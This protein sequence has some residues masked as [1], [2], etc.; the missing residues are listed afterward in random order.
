MPIKSPFERP[1]D[2]SYVEQYPN[3]RAQVKMR[4]TQPQQSTPPPITDRHGFVQQTSPFLTERYG[5][6][7]KLFLTLVNNIVEDPDY[8]LRKD[9]KV[10][11]RMLRD[12]QIHYCLEVRKAATTSLEW[13]VRPPDAFMQDSTALKLASDAY[14]RLY[15]IKHITALF[16][17]ILDGMLPGLSVNELV[18]KI[19]SKGQY[20]VERHFPMNKDRFLFD[21]VGNL[22]LKQPV[23]VVTGV[24]V[25]PYKFIAKTF[26]ASDGS[27]DRPEDAGYVF[28]GKGLADTPLYH[29]FYF[30]MAALRYLLK[31]LEQYGIPTKI[32]YT[33][34][35][36]I[37]LTSRLTEILTALQNDSVVGIPGKKGD[38]DVDVSKQATGGTSMNLFI[39]FIEYVDRLITRCILG[40]ELM[41]EMPAV[42]S[43]AAAQV[44]Q[45]VFARIAET[46]KAQLQD[47]INSTL[48]RYD[49]EL[50]T[51]GVP[52][53]MRPIFLF[54]SS[55]MVDTGSFLQSVSTAIQL[56]LTISEAQ[57]R[58]LTGLREPQEGEAVLSAQTQMAIQQQQL[59]MQAEMTPPEE[60][61]SGIDAKATENAKDKSKT[62]SASK[63]T[64]PS[65]S[66]K[67]SA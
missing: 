14:H 6:F 15:Q 47:T 25:P 28:F 10:Y 61:E 3:I 7:D 40:Q 9:P 17:N 44:H 31:T 5:G 62:K 18:W 13:Q 63:D 45:S 57:V 46:D 67:K 32:F 39:Q 8:A 12:P 16:D 43:Y 55:P 59:Q 34:A 36:N 23:S 37:Q 20:I 29:Y 2:N 35:G 1:V 21:R 49:C 42:G 11:R 51:P 33:G 52:E 22:R 54:K 41:T 65:K 50:N 60:K 4:T 38:V 53:E 30:K 58:E 24:E 26:N 48:L 56:G 27:W 66:A 19:D 64:P